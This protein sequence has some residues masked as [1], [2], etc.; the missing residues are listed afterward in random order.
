MRWR[1][2]IILQGLLI[3]IVG[4]I[5]YIHNDKV[6]LRKA[7]PASLAQWYMPENKRQVW[8]HTMFNLRREMQ[9][10]KL[11]STGNEAELLDKWSAL[12]R[13]HY[14]EISEMVPEWNKKLDK[15]ALK[16]LQTSVKARDQQGI[17]LALDDINKTCDSCHQDYRSTVA[18]IYRAPDF[19][20]IKLSKPVEYNE[21]MKTLVEQ[22][23]QVKIASEDGKRDVALS[24]LS[25]LKHGINLQ[26]ETC[27]QCH[28][29]DTRVYP[30]AEMIKTIASLEQSLVNGTRKE[31]GR[32]LGTLAVQA[33]ARCHGTHRIAYDNRKIFVDGPN[34]REL[35]KH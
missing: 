24:S 18:T 22:V 34:W 3:A 12:L 28:K 14:L 16:R 30:D 8:L 29:K 10:V 26:G 5:F 9:A 7:P 23:N 32:A 27:V 31:Q 1:Y 2:F 35:I 11:Y 33:C 17:S 6:S 13:K 25:E 4:S 15:D 19:S 21:H 20:S